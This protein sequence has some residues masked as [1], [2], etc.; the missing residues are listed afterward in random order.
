MR[1]SLRCPAWQ[2]QLQQAP[3]RAPPTRQPGSQPSPPHPTRS[4]SFICH[5]PFKFSTCAHAPS[6]P[7]SSRAAAMPM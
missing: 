6:A 3:S 5:P 7:F 4:S 1:K 2:L